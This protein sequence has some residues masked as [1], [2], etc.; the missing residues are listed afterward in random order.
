MSSVIDLQQR[1][2]FVFEIEVRKT[3]KVELCTSFS[4]KSKSD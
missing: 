3:T 4:F 2:F 1:I